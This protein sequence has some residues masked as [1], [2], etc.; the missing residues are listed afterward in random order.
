MH[1]GLGPDGHTASLFPG[2]A[3]LDVTDRLVVANGDDA[4]PHP[5]LT[6]TFPALAR[7]RLVVFTVAGEDKRE[8]FARIRAGEDL[9]GGRVDRRARALA[10]RSGRRG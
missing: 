7:S 10:G 6:F 2:T 9:P 4:H 3:A 5:R 1:L 8:P